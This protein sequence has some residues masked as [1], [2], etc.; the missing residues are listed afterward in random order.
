[1]EP[2]VLPFVAASG[3]AAAAA[4]TMHMSTPRPTQPPPMGRVYR[5]PAVQTTSPDYSQRPPLKILQ[6]TTQVNPTKIGGRL[7]IREPGDVV[8]LYRVLVERGP[9]HADLRSKL[10]KHIIQTKF[11]QPHIDENDIRMRA[12]K[13]RKKLDTKSF[14]SFT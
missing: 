11:I 12:D 2:V 4:V 9:K 3:M 7:E 10:E 13:F 6:P 8:A 5:M 14:F 1:M